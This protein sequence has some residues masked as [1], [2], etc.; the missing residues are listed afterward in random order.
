VAAVTLISG[1]S[2]HTLIF[3]DFAFDGIGTATYGAI[4]LHPLLN[5]RS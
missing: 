2:E 1:A 3:G 4:G 5:R